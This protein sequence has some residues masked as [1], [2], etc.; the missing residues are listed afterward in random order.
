V[1]FQDGPIHDTK[2]W[3]GCLGQ[4]LGACASRPQ[5]KTVTGLT[6]VA[7]LAQNLP[8]VIYCM[9]CAAEWIDGDVTG[10][11][12]VNRPSA[13]PPPQDRLPYSLSLERPP[14]TRRRLE[15]RS[16]PEDLA[17]NLRRRLCPN[18]YACACAEETRRFLLPSRRA[19]LRCV[20]HVQSIS[21]NYYIDRASA[22]YCSRNFC[23]D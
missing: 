10:H 22:R 17:I 13:P 5:Q 7:S 12:D 4:N 20:L 14:F 8:Y 1:A 21:Q 15:I 19:V 11:A 6:G 9:H 3:G 23:A 18:I 2:K 16:L